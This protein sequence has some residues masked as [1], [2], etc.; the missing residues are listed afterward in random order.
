MGKLF[1]PTADDQLWCVL[2]GTGR[3][4]FY[5]VP[6]LARDSEFFLI[7][8]AVSLENDQLLWLQH[9]LDALTSF[10]VSGHWLASRE[11]AESVL[12]KCPGITPA[13]YVVWGNTKVDK[14]D[15]SVDGSSPPDIQ[16]EMS[17]NADR[18]VRY[19]C[20][21]AGIADISATRI[22]WYRFCQA[23]VNWM[24]V[25]GRP[26]DMLFGVMTTIPLRRNW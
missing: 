26:L 11:R 2:E 13:Y 24:V 17:T 18:F 6:G 14:P 9:H 16:D 10:K 8:P 21:N 15:H 4:P 23:A 20:N 1:T 22:L 12:H 25:E 3:L 19:V 7:S 5:V